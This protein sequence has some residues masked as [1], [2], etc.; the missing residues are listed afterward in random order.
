MKIACQVQWAVLKEG[1]GEEFVV[2][3]LDWWWKAAGG[4]RMR[5]NDVLMGGGDKGR[6]WNLSEPFIT[7]IGK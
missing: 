4:G 1:K 7:R 5:S 3:G 2:E 6:T